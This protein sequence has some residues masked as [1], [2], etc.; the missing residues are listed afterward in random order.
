M[1]LSFQ[2]IY[3]VVFLL[4]FYLF[5]YNNQAIGNIPIIW[6]A[7]SVNDYFTGR[8]REL[9]ELDKIIKSHH[10]AIIIG[11]GGI[12]KTQLAKKY[13]HTFQNNYEMVWWFDM[14]KN[15]NDQINGL[16]YHLNKNNISKI[17]ID[18]EK[19]SGS[20]LLLYVK[21]ALRTTNKTWL[22]IFDNAKNTDVIKNLIPETHNNL[23]KNIIITSRNSNEVY[24]SLSLKTF[25]KQEAI[26]FLSKTLS[27]KDTASLEQLAEL[28]GFYPIALAQAAAYITVNNMQVSEYINI[29]NKDSARLWQNEKMFLD[30]ES[31]YFD[32]NQKTIDTSIKINLKNIKNDFPL[33]LEILRG[34]SLIKV[35]I[36][37]EHLV[38]EI[39]KIS[40]NS[41]E[42]YKAAIR[43]LKKYSLIQEESKA[44]KKY[45]QVHD[46]IK[47]IVKQE[48]IKSR[49]DLVITY[50][51]ILAS[52]YKYLNKPWGTMVNEINNNA[53]LVNIAT[54][55][56]INSY[57]DK[58]F[59]PVLA[60]LIT[61]LLEHN[62]ML[63]HP[64][65][66]YLSYQELAG[67]GFELIEKHKVNI[68]LSLQARYY[69]GSIYSDF[70]FNDQNIKSLYEKKLIELI[71]FLEHSPVQMEALFLSCINMSKFYMFTGDFKQATFYI[72]KAYSLLNKVTNV[73]YQADFWYTI[74]WLHIEK[75][76]YN[77]A[78]K[79]IQIFFNITKHHEI[80]PLHL[81]AM[82][83]SALIEFNLGN[84]KDSF[85]LA[86]KCY[87]DAKKFFQTEI[88]NISAES[89]T[90]LARY[91]QASKN[92]TKAKDKIQQAI[93]VLDIVF[94]NPEIDPSQ[95]VAHTLLGEI[96]EAQRNYKGAYEEYTFA[97]KY[98]T[99]LYKDKI[100]DVYEISKLYANLAILGLKIHDY[101]LA[102][103]YFKKLLDIFSLKNSNTKKVMEEMQKYKINLLD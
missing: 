83:M 81:Y 26:R 48:V 92:Y 2:Q 61:S 40:G 90:T 67:I 68:P 88:S 66:N 87:E 20:A 77:N 35:S 91:Y 46:L 102:R 6:N 18:I 9:K 93:K 53:E 100:E 14:S 24:P 8:D 56:A 10:K 84:L 41:E 13:V 60:E 58:V 28:L 32:L 11:P 21:E 86:D 69:F 36:V 74:T 103:Q 25:P 85:L 29:Y 42:D 98:Y 12:G 7:P 64:N 52:L 19:I 51:K 82:N 73:N 5:I 94:G 37:P 15:I 50:S 31:D 75:A 97:E 62:N 70:I 39:A 4:L 30:S 33:S 65:S 59:V 101:S 43:T 57:K 47:A 72:D 16:A 76:D 22:V 95:A 80:Y 71:S 49:E 1:L 17:K 78:H 96:Y 63:F 27:K 54:T 38:G 55:V 89:L 45:Y 44:D 79:Y 99:K 3:K 34:I 23:G